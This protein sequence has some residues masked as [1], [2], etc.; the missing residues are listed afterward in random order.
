M[1]E[2][3]SKDVELLTGSA[4]EPCV[5]DVVPQSNRWCAVGRAVGRVDAERAPVAGRW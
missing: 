3:Q 1:Y 4:A 2:K 5:V